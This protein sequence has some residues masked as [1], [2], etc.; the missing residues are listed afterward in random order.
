MTTPARW[1]GTIT[2]NVRAER[3]RQRLGQPDVSKRMRQ[4]GFTN[5]YPGTMGKVERGERNL[6]AE[7]VIG[8]AIVLATTPSVLMAVT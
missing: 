2:A 1:S 3:A 5:W 8:L 6:L 4:L 7:E